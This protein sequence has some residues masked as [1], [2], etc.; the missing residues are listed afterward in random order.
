MINKNQ[1][2]L[3]EKI[4]R[5]VNHYNTG[6]YAY[7]IRESN[8][9]LKKIPNNT[10]VCNLLGSCFQNLGELESAKKIFRNILIKNP[11]NLAAMNNL[12]NTHKN[13]REF[14]EAEKHYKKIL[15]IQPNYIHAI[16]N[17]AN[18]NFDI[19]KYELAIKLYDEALKIDKDNLL[20]NY[21]SA[22]SHQ[23]LGNFE[24]AKLYL[25]EVLRIN[26]KITVADKLL[27]RVT[28]YTKNN[29]HL[30][31]MEEKV[32]DNS[33]SDF[34]KSNLFFALGKAYEDL[35]EYNRSFLYL[36]KGNVLKK[37]ITKYNSKLD[38]KLF[39]NL[40]DFFK[41][42][43]FKNINKINTNNKSM[44]FILGM[45]RSGTSLVEQ[46]ISS[47]TQVYGAGELD[48]LEILIANNFNK[49]NVFNA[50]I[51][52]DT[53]S[54]NNFNEI[55]T[56][57]HKFLETLE[58]KEKFITD[59]AP[60]NFLWIGFIK[61]F[62]PNAKIIHC[63]RDPKDNCLS[64]YKNVFDKNLNWTYSQ[65]DLSEYYINYYQLMKFWNIKIP[66]FIYNVSYEN[67]ISKPDKEIKNL[68]KYCGLGWE[69]K[70][71]K[72]YNNKK[73]I[74]TVSSA[75]A[76]QRLYNSSISSSKNYEAYLSVLFSNLEK[77]KL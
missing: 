18:L 14:K 34:E 75:Q 70:C 26:P 47:H 20:L 65:S 31:E 56:Q 66:N 55:S 28:K 44:I 53:N 42:Y 39:T 35:L 68:I 58:A 32:E 13:L 59:K 12:A 6:N 9:L 46:I 49:N 60:L 10:F 71:L 73:P 21:N 45:P 62:F 64:L 50:N 69:D 74:K 63:V 41:D 51:L 72:F 16:V 22:L 1:K 57:Y 38:N 48:Y 61:I 5:L 25:R 30:I 67:L 43:N 2:I 23:S 37:K 3:K 11:K 54:K 8:L 7:V 33:L 4:A 29:D 19:N 76:R 52:K 77:L 15:T 40:K 24:K 36:E 17:Y 27:S